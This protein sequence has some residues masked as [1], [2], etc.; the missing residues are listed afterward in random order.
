MK[1]VDVIGVHAAYISI[2][3]AEQVVHIL[4]VPGLT[5]CVRVTDVWI[6]NLFIWL[7]KAQLYGILEYL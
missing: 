6:E 2:D 1:P 4:V 3:D 5:Y 7:I